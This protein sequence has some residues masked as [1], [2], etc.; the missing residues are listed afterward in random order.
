[1]TSFQGFGLL[2]CFLQSAPCTRLRDAV[3][4]KVVVE[5]KVVRSLRRCAPQRA[6]AELRLLLRLTPNVGPILCSTSCSR[7]TK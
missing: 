2:A 5:P 4:E 1:M 7:L 3:N 6:I